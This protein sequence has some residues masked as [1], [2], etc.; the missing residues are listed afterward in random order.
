VI[1][2]PGAKVIRSDIRGPAIV[3]EGTVIEDSRLGPNTSISFGCTVSGSTIEDS[4][5]MEG[6]RIEGV[7][8]VSGSL[9]GK[10][11]EVRRP[12]RAGSHRLVVGDQSQVEIDES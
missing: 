1:V 7:R 8:G 10:N 6:C 11:V 2:E 3:G 12:P 4:I 5:V 9:L